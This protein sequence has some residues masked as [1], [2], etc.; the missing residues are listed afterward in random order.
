M[1]ESIPFEGANRRLVSPMHEPEVDLI[2]DKPDMF[3]FNNGIIT[4]TRWQ[5]TPEE[6]TEIAKTGEVWVATRDGVNPMRPTWVGS[7]STIKE[8]CLGY[9]RFWKRKPRPQALLEDKREPA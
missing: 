8:M 3:G 5:L 1:A 9:G 4:Y 2:N 6:I 7:F